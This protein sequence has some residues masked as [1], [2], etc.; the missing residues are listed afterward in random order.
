MDLMEDSV[1]KSLKEKKIIFL[2]VPG[3][4]TKYVQVFDVLL[5][6]PFKANVSEMYDEQL[7]TDGIKN[8]TDA[9]NLKS[10]PS[11]VTVKW[12]MKVRENLTPEF[13]SRSFKTCALN[14]SVGRSEDD[15]THCFKAGQPCKKGFSL[16]KD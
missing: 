6:E 9:G 8:L 10:P 5:N 2:L 3:G 14:I 12:I 1:S 15:A 11:C 16:P 4:C 7:F 13:V